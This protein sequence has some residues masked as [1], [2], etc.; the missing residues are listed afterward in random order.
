[1]SRT[2]SLTFLDS[3][4]QSLDCFDLVGIYDMGH[5]DYDM[6]RL[7]WQLKESV[8]QSPTFAG[9]QRLVFVHDDLDFFFDRNC[10]PVTLYNL[11]LILKEL[12]ISNNFCIVISN[13]PNYDR[14]TRMAQT[15]LT[16]DSHPIQAITSL[17]TSVMDFE[18]KPVSLQAGQAERLF[19][20]QSRMSR[21]HRTY[22]MSQL[23]AENLLEYGLAGYHNMPPQSDLDQYHEFN[24]P[25]E[26][27]PTPCHF[28]TLNPFVRDNPTVLIRRPQNQD[29]VRIFQQTVPRLQNYEEDLN[30]M[31][32]EAANGLQNTVIPRALIY[33]GLETTVNTPEPFMTNITFKGIVNLRP[34]I[35]VGCP[36]ILRY[37]RQQGFKTFGDYW[38]ESYDDENDFETRV[39]MIIDI[40]RS[41]KKRKDFS[42]VLKHMKPILDHNFNHYQQVFV[43]QQHQL[44]KQ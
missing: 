17:L 5:Y 32:K 27:R 15:Q 36:G 11:Q 12:D 2:T 31:D 37:L 25:P 6:G 28:L 30:I 13:L 9:N 24:Q 7:Y 26:L 33:I 8:G 19:S 1:M 38:D 10:V 34:F 3:V 14:Y 35:P 44:I 41:W 39:D 20:A 22:F 42:N 18:I 29:R 16:T 40:L 23:Y 43:P 21:F 4:R